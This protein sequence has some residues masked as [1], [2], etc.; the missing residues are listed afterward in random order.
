[1]KTVSQQNFLNNGVTK[2]NCF[3]SRNFSPQKSNYCVKNFNTRTY[4]C[5]D[6]PEPPSWYACALQESTFRLSPLPPLS[7][8]SRIKFIFCLC[9]STA[10][11]VDG[12]KRKSHLFTLNGV[13]P[14]SWQGGSLSQIH[15]SYRGTLA[16]IFYIYDVTYS[17]GIALTAGHNTTGMQPVPIRRFPQQQYRGESPRR[18]QMLRESPIWTRSVVFRKTGNTATLSHSYFPTC[19]FSPKWE[20]DFR[21]PF[22]RLPPVV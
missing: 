8:C 17:E 5:I 2:I 15:T 7:T 4:R 16:C 19:R 6:F 9:S 22:A 21:S 18:C 1:M 11:S 12:Q 13:D 14:S 3:H 20:T 10:A